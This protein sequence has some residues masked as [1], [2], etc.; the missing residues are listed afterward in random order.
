MSTLL[1][2]PTRGEAAHLLRRAPDLARRARLEICGFGPVVAAAR[3][4]QLLADETIDRVILAGIAGTYDH[5]RHPV[6]SVLEAGSVALDGVGAGEGDSF[7]SAQDLGF[8]LF[9]GERDDGLS[10]VEG[11]LSLPAPSGGGLLLTVCSSTAAEAQLARRR[12]LHPEAA[13][14]DM[15]GYGVAVACRFRKIQLRIL[16]GI[17]N[18]AG[19]RDRT[20]WEIE[21]ALGA[22]AERTEEILSA[23]P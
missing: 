6:G 14:E 20:R 1:L 9:E 12:A 15:E 2:I 22:V 5:E 8:L 18:R 17:S 16:R 21:G 7:L 4:A 11:V 3:T 13:M 10:R 23:N 19:D